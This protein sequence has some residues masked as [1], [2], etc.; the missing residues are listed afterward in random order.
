MTTF[1]ST[2]NREALQI[3][4]AALVAEAAA[5]DAEARARGA[6]HHRG[7]AC[8][9]ARDNGVEAAG[10]IA[11]AA[12][13]AVSE[14]NQAKAAHETAMAA[15]KECNRLLHRLPL[16]EAQDEMTPFLRRALRATHR[17]TDARD[18]A[19]AEAQ[20]ALGARERTH[21]TWAKQADTDR[22]LA[23]ADAAAKAAG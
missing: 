14:S 21:D 5:D 11:R 10:T 6:K 4:D 2:P 7:N 13:G 15:H 12:A 3:L 22:A 8:G 17:S 18:A 19:H 20:D 23:Q 16:R 1:E 9:F